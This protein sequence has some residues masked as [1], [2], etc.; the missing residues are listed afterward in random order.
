MENPEENKKDETPDIFVNWRGVGTA[1][2]IILCLFGFGILA[3]QPWI[4]GIILAIIIFANSSHTPPAGYVDPK[5]TQYDLKQVTRPDPDNTVRPYVLRHRAHPVDY[6]QMPSKRWMEER[7]KADRAFVKIAEEENLKGYAL[8][9]RFYEVNPIFL[10]DTV[11]NTEYTPEAMKPAIKEQKEKD[12]GGEEWWNFRAPEFN[13]QE[14]EWMEAVHCDL[15]FFE[16]LRALMDI[17]EE[18][19]KLMKR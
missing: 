7:L 17:R 6:Y 10:K 9:R 8:T 16:L 5:K 18:K 3:F 12:P 14:L 4:I 19:E 11:K 1:V 13:Y 15:D 2:I